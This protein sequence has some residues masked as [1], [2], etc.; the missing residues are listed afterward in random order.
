[1]DVYIFG[2]MAYFDEIQWIHRIIC[3]M[4]NTRASVN[5]NVNVN[6]CI[7]TYLSIYLYSPYSVYDW[8]LYV[9][10][11][12]VFLKR[13][14]S[15]IDS[16]HLTDAHTHFPS[17]FHTRLLFSFSF[18]NENKFPIDLTWLNSIFLTHRKSCFSVKKFC[19]LIDASIQ[20]VR[21][22]KHFQKLNRKQSIRLSTIHIKMWIQRHLLMVAAKRIRKKTKQNSLVCFV[23]F[24]WIFDFV[25]FR[26]KTAKMTHIFQ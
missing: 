23:S 8:S 6:V 19:S 11:L 1:M 2:R 15:T 3:N 10:V 14:L 25:R 22:K 4:T 5:V 16:Y 26:F 20:C 13:H 18:A 9:R 21:R 24:F 7:H 12:F 17:L